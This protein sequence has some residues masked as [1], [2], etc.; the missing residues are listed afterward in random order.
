MGRLYGCAAPILTKLPELSVGMARVSGM[1][2][3]VCA[4]TVDSEKALGREEGE[5]ERNRLCD[6]AFVRFYPRRS[7]RC[8]SLCGSCWVVGSQGKST[9]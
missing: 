9:A 2:P 3:A 4:S 1:P 8:V 5:G 6:V 7:P